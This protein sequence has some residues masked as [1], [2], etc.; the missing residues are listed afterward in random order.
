MTGAPGAVRGLFGGISPPE[1]DSAS[2]QVSTWFDLGGGYDRNVDRTGVRPLAVDGPATTMLGGFRFWRGKTTRAFEVNA[3]IFR[4]HQRAGNVTASGGE[5]NLLGNLETRRRRGGLNFAMRG[6]NDN[7]VLFG[8]TGQAA[9][10][11]P[12]ID[13]QFAVPDVSP[14]LGAVQQRWYTLAGNVTAYRN[15]SVEQRTTVQYSQTHRQPIES[16]QFDTD[17][18]LIGLTHNWAFRNNAAVF[19]AYRFEDFRQELPQ[20]ST[21][22]PIRT[23]TVEAGTR[24][25]R[26]FSPIRAFAVSLQGGATRVTDLAPAAGAGDLSTVPTGALTA[27]YTLTRRLV[28]GVT[29]ARSITV[30]QGAAQAAFTSNVASMALTGVVAQRITVVAAGSYS[31]GNA[32]SAAPGEFESVGGAAT[33]RYAMRYGAFFT[34]LTRYTHRLEGVGARTLQGGIRPRFEQSSLRA[35]VTIWLPL[36]GAF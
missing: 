7:A 19:A 27:S 30:L 20:L 11:R 29:G 22:R 9:P 26:R 34:S 5:V 32:L 33:V 35:G 8:A 12:V 3:R 4:N 25:E 17:Q 15:W 28:L 1:P 10:V 6:G 2:Q 16:E 23:H 21:L 13:P 14:P 36:L 31:A 18:R 24:W